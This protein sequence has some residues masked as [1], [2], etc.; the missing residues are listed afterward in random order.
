MMEKMKSTAA[1]AVDAAGDMGRKVG[2]K[3][4]IV[5]INSRISELKGEIEKLYGVIGEKV[6]QTPGDTIEKAAFEQELKEIGDRYN[7]I[8]DCLYRTAELKGMVICPGCG[9]ECEKEADFCS[10]CGTKLVK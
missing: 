9:K 4:E 10:K 5:K 1:A 2:E 6:Y 7:Q 3:F 8:K